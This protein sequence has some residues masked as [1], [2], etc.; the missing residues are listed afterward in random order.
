[1]RRHVPFWGWLLLIV[2][3]L[4]AIYNPLGFCV[5]G[6]WLLGEEVALPVKL[7][8]TAIPVALLGL[9]VYGTWRSIGLVGIAILAILLGLTLWV[10]AYF[11]ILDPANAGLW[12]WMTQPLLAL[13]LAVGFQW[14]RIW[15]GATGQ[16]SVD[17]IDAHGREVN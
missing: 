14:S 16:V 17:D 11:S 13:I 6:L 9:Y 4:Y 7:L 3:T 10:L 15:R 12:S 1:M 8:V 2:A 5:L